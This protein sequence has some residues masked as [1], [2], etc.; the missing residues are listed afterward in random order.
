MS[1]IGGSGRRRVAEDAKVV[2]DR[3]G[4]QVADAADRVVD[5]AAKG[6][7]GEVAQELKDAAGDLKGAA[8]EHGKALFE[9]AKGQ[10][11]GFVDERKNEAAR[12]VAEIAASLRET[13]NS[14]GERP[15]IQAFVGSAADGLEQLATS[16]Q[17]RS[18]AD[19]YSDAE[20]YARRSPVTVAAVAAVA[21]FLLARF[22]KSSS[23]ELAETG[24]ARAS[25]RKSAARRAASRSHES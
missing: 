12:S 6:D 16:I 9:S 7:L 17:E 23:E 24:A 19:L 22:I 1:E 25:A 8:V 13:G 5:K 14:F 11:T 3:L 2:G 4:P 18:F 20:A 10:A 21:G 15:N